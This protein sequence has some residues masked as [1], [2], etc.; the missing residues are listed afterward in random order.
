MSEK[1]LEKEREIAEKRYFAKSPYLLV[2]DQ[3]DSMNLLIPGTLRYRPE[4]EHLMKDIDI[5]PKEDKDQYE[6]ALAQN[7]LLMGICSDPDKLT[8][9]VYSSQKEEK[10]NSSKKDDKKSKKSK[11]KKKK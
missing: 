3:M 8:Q 9:P 7:M 4:H 10:E 1:D 5:T 2:V 11:N 6:A